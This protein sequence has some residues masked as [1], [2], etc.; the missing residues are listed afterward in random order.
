M[1]LLVRLSD[2]AIGLAL[3]RRLLGRLGR[4]RVERLAYGVFGL[5]AVEGEAESG[6]RLSTAIFGLP[7][8]HGGILPLGHSHSN[9]LPQ[10]LFGIRLI[11]PRSP[12]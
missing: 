9:G 3:L 11:D 10:K 4:R 12:T 1:D 7:V 2:T 8:A 5:H 6:L